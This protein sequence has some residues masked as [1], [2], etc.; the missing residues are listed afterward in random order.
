MFRTLGDLNKEEEKGENETDSYTGGEK[1]G[2][3]VRNPNERQG[4]GDPFDSM[5]N[6]AR[7]DTG[8]ED[9]S[10]REAV[11]IIV[12]LLSLSRMI[13]DRLAKRHL[14]SPHTHTISFGFCR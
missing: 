4:G 5:V 1:S 14:L 3:A 13:D 6:K 7:Q 12:I 11:S 10:D 9:P 8:K 2:I